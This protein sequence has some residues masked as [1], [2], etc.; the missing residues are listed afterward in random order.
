MAGE[1]SRSKVN[2]SLLLLGSIAVGAYQL[3]AKNSADSNKVAADVESLRGDMRELVKSS[4]A[5]KTECSNALRSI[6]VIEGR[7]QVIQSE[8]VQINSKIR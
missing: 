3:G 5:L 1:A 8:Q 4:D 2:I 6:T 7:I